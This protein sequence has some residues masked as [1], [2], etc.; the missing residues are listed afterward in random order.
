MKHEEDIFARAK[1]YKYNSESLSEFL[2]LIFIN[3]KI[4]IILLSFISRY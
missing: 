2:I 1:Q 3:F 4:T